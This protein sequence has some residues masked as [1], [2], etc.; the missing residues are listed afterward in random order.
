MKSLKTVGR[1]RV[2]R[3]TSSL[4]LAM[5]AAAHAA[6]AEHPAGDLARLLAKSQIEDLLIDY[7]ALFT[8]RAAGDFG[9]FY[10]DDGVLDVNGIV[11]KGREPINA[12]YKGINEAGKIHILITN[13][14]VV[15]KSD[16][17]ASADFVWTEVNSES[18][19]AIPRITEQGREHDDLVKRSGHWYFMK[20]VVTN[21]GG[22]PAALEKNYIER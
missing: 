19:L 4:V 17:S 22:M 12:L 16:D 15:V 1:K 6:P 5:A 18:H 14:K 13:L 20:R 10:I 7:Y 2:V 21:D 3:V 9:S 11:R 8:N